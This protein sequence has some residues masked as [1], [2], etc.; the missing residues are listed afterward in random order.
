[1]NS[2]YVTW[3]LL[4]R[5][6]SDWTAAA[7]RFVKRLLGESTKLWLVHHK[8][9]KQKIY[10]DLFLELSGASLSLSKEL[11]SQEY[12]VYSEEIFEEGAN[13]LIKELQSN[14]FYEASTQATYILGTRSCEYQ[15][16]V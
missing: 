6:T 16:I 12:A 14:Q 3:S 15:E 2:D 8:I 11:C 10:G 1:M 5:V 9:V 13:L 7:V 4:Y